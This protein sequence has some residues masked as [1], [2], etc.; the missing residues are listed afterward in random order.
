MERRL[1]RPAAFAC[2][3]HPPAHNVGAE[4]L[5]GVAHHVIDRARLA[6]GADLQR[7]A[8]MFQANEPAHQGSPLRAPILEAGIIPVMLA[9]PVTDDDADAD[10]AGG[11]SSTAGCRLHR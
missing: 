5:A 2:L 3:E 8:E 11:G 4:P 1:F 7:A 6:A 10:T 9:K